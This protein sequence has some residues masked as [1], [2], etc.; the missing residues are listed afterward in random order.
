MTCYPCIL[1]GR[2]ADRIGVFVPDDPAKSG[3]GSPPEGKLRVARYGLC[4][5]HDFNRRMVLILIEQELERLARA[6][7]GVTP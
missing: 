6:M 2:P 7:E 5:R 3:L 4:N 1:C